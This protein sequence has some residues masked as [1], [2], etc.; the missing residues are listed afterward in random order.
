[1]GGQKGIAFFCKYLGEQ[2][3]LTAVS[4]NNNDIELAET[5]KIIP[6]FSK[7]RLRY[8]NP[9]YVFRIKKIIKKHDIKNVI[10]EHPYMA[11]MAWMLKKTLHVKWFVHSHNIEFERF[12][13]LNKRWFKILKFYEK[14]SYKNADKVFFKTN[15]D[16]EF[17]VKNN[18]IKKENAVLVPFGVEIKQMPFDR[19]EHKKKICAAI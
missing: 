1:M 16:I 12:R 10:T 19:I 7:K 3:E 4:V 2:N 6:L 9:F 13:T 8:L 18:M 11:W 14:W 15:E 5:Y 17:A